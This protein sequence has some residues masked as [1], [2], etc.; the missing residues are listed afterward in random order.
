MYT[1]LVM[2]YNKSS[3]MDGFS[4]KEGW[5]SAESGQSFCYSLSLQYVAS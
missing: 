1:Q 2:F 5:K 4:V 3:G